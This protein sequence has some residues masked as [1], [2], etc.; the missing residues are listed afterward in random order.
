MNNKVTKLLSKYASISDTSLKDLKKWWH[1]LSWQ[2]KTVERKKMEAELAGEFEET[3]ETQ[4]TQETQ[5][6]A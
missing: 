3:E 4:E 1:T 6:T 5:E 2:E